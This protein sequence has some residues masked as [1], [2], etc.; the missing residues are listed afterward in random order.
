MTANAPHPRPWV[1]RVLACAGLAVVLWACATAW[2][3]VV[4]GHPAYAIVLA[5]TLLGA[6]AVLV[7]AG[8]R[9]WRRGSVRTLGRF[10][11]VAL[12]IV[13]L[14]VVGWLR[15]HT[16]EAPALEAMHEDAAVAVTETATTITFTPVGATDESTG[17]VFQPGAL[18][19]PRAYA[20]VL[21][22]VAEAGHPVVIV[23][24]PLG[25]A[26]TALGALD[27][28]TQT[29]PDVERWVIGGHSL[30]GTVAALTAEN[31]DVAGLVLF[32]AYPVGDM[33][34]A[35][36]PVLSVSGTRDGL[37]TPQK[38]AASSENLPAGSD[39][40]VIAGASHAQ[41]GGYGAQSGDGIPSITHDDARA[42]ITRAV[43]DFLNQ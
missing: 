26:F 16:A 1:W 42:Q 11:L 12:G 4:H 40:V 28:A 36:V 14:G 8:V 18:V 41:F 37:S 31:S 9:E 2:G 25:I 22:P 6:I 5:V 10:I 33:S 3:G 30:G 34:D 19:D 32:A 35:G 39:F 24:Q 38:I 23:K 27:T 20:T 13:W 17:L 43:L 29:L 7:S 15:P 21:R